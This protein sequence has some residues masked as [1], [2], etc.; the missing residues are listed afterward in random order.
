MEEVVISL[1]INKW[2][3]FVVIVAVFASFISNAMT[4]YIHYLKRR[5]AKES[6][7]HDNSGLNIPDV[8]QQSG[9]L[10]FNCQKEPKINTQTGFC[11]KCFV[12]WNIGKPI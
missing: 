5:I 6:N 4:L 8:T 9:Q 2:M 3:L 1:T 12:D 10:C 7:L 11:K